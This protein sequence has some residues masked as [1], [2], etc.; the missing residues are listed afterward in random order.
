MINAEYHRNWRK[1]NPEKVKKYN[2]RDRKKYQKEKNKEEFIIKR[3]IK[4]N[5]WKEKNKQ[6][7]KELRKNYYNKNKSKVWSREITRR[8]LKFKN[9]PISIKYKCKKCG[10]IKNLQ[11]HHEIYPFNRKEIRE[12]I[13]KGKIYFLCKKHHKHHKK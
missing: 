9:K 1:K 11:I 6:R 3:R 4:F 13:K 7:Y 2:E 12:A 8:V 5:K 10:S